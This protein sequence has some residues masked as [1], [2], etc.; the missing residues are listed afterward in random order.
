MHLV[1]VSP[2]SILLLFMHSD[3]LPLPQLKLVSLYK[4]LLK[5]GLGI[6][7]NLKL[8]GLCFFAEAH[9]R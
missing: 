6:S 9:L 8:I 2:L 7:F 1:L 4:I 3:L 5:L